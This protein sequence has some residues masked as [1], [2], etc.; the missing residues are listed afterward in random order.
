ME[1]EITLVSSI[2]NER[3]ELTPNKIEISSTTKTSEVN[4]EDINI[5]DGDP[6]SDGENLSS[7]A[8]NGYEPTA[9]K[10]SVVISSC[11][12]ERLTMSRCSGRSHSKL[13]LQTFSTDDSGYI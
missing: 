8:A 7:A 4:M 2:P 10:R 13:S 5:V 3:E 6:N 12:D 11:G 1:S 9:S